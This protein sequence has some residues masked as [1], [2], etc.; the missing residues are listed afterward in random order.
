MPHLSFRIKQ[1]YL[2]FEVNGSAER[3][4]YHLIGICARRRGDRR[5]TVKHENKKYD[6]FGA[7]TVVQIK[8]RPPRTEDQYIKIDDR[9]RISVWFYDQ[10]DEYAHLGDED[11]HF[12]ASISLPPD[13]Y[14]RVVDNDWSKQH[15]ILSVSTMLSSRAVTY[16]HAPDG[17]EVEWTAGERSDADLESFSIE[18]CSATETD[19]DQEETEKPASP[20]EKVLASVERATKAIGELRSSVIMAAWLLA[21]VVVVA[22]FIK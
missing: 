20:L 17:S 9:D 14:Q 7:K 2:S 16:S 1:P 8:K 21:A 10:T 11:P 22:A 3:W 5:L 19:D 18:F 4:H 12:E 13:A 6:G 15:L